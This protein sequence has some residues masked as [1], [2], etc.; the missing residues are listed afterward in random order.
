MQQLQPF[1]PEKWAGQIEMRNRGP[2]I[3]LGD[4][5]ADGIARLDRFLLADEQ[6]RRRSQDV[7]KQRPIRGTGRGQFDVD[8]RLRRGLPLEIRKTDRRVGN[9]ARLRPICTAADVQGKVFPLA[10]EPPDVRRRAERADGVPG[11][12]FRIAGG[13]C[14]CPCWLA[15]LLQC[16]RRSPAARRSADGHATIIPPANADRDRPCSAGPAC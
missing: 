1:A 6:H 2:G 9:H 4:H 10:R 16:P 15:I 7:R 11:D 13:S 5:V 12:K 8:G 14:G 3:E